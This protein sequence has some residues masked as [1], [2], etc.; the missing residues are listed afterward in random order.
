MTDVFISYSRRDRDFVQI[1]HDALVASKFQAWIDWQDIAP[2]AEWWKEIE[3]GIESAHT[4]LF[5]ISKDSI[6]SRYCRKEIDH[7][8]QHGKRLIPILRRKDYTRT[9]LHP[10]LGQHQWIAFQEEDDFDQAFTTLVQA[11]NTDLDYKKAHTRW[12]IRAVEWTQG[13]KDDS[14]LLRGKE[15]LKAEEW[16]LKADSSQEPRPTLLQK[17]Y[18]AAS[19]QKINQEQVKTIRRQRLTLGVLAG[20]LLLAIGTGIWAL[21]QRQQAVAGE[22]KALNAQL[23]AESLTLQAYL[24]AGLEKPAVVQ[25]M[26]TAMALSEHSANR[27]AIQD[28]IL[29]QALTAIEK[30]VTESK[31]KGRLI[32]HQAPIWSVAF[33]LDGRILATASGDKTV[34]LWNRD[35]EELVT[36]PHRDVVWDV[37]FS[38]E[39]YT[40]EIATAGKD[41]TAALWSKDGKRLRTFRGHSA[42]IRSLAFS[43][44]GKTLATAS[45]DQSVKLWNR[46]GQVLKT[47]NG[48]NGEVYAVAFS[49]RGDILATASADETVKIW[50]IDGQE[51]FTLRGHS[52]PVHTVAFSH[53]GET[54]ASAGADM[55][56][57]LWSANGQGL[58]TFYGHKDKIWHVAFGPT[59]E[60]LV[61]ASEDNTIKQWDRKGRVL[62]TLGGHNAR[63]WHVAFDR[64]GQ[65]LASGSSDNTVKLWD[66]A[67][68]N[69]SPVNP[70]QQTQVTALD[71]AVDAPNPASN[72]QVMVENQVAALN[73]VA[74]NPADDSQP[75]TNP[76]SWHEHLEGLIVRG[77]N[78]LKTYFVTQSPDLLMD[79]DVCHE[80]N[81]ALKTEVA[82]LLA[83]QGDQ[84][85]REGNIHRAKILFQQ[86]VDWDQRLAIDPQTRV[87]D[88]VRAQDLVLEAEGLARVGNLPAAEAKLT[89]AKS[90]DTS[91]NYIPEQKAREVRVK[92]LLQ[93]AEILAQAGDQETVRARIQQAKTLDPSLTLDPEPWARGLR[94]Q[95]LM[96]T[97]QELAQGNDLPEAIRQLTGAKALH[98]SLDLVPEAQAKT[99]RIEHLMESAE[100]L[101]RSNQLP[102]AR[103]QLTE[104]KA[105]DPSLDLI[106]EEQANQWRVEFLMET[107]EELA[108]D[109]D[110][111]TA[112]EHLAEAKKLDPTLPFDPHN[113]AEELAVAPYLRE[114]QR[115]AQDGNINGAIRSYLQAEFSGLSDYITAQD[116]N[117]I[118]RLG[119]T[120]D[121]ATQAMFACQ[122]AVELAPDDGSILDSRGIAKALTGNTSGAITDFRSFI[123]WSSDG[124]EIAQRQQW[125]EALERNQNPFTPD[126]LK[127]LR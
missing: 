95:F 48:H 76:A 81:P 47:L 40:F 14:A 59:D 92:T 2:T 35:G 115:L 121:Q 3:T 53:D 33:S 62:Q 52:R 99:W 102:T 10:K 26:Q 24:E 21:D 61:S 86:A 75:Q 15:L 93:E 94:V 65:T 43:P 6:S 11:I 55:T 70:V 84:L 12:E 17:E 16:L 45:A 50:S 122:K 117:Q 101:A 124:G 39:R 67:R 9:D 118:C 126:V 31:E 116:W 127:S 23:L 91:L 28:D 78:W 113:Q 71:A 56:V 73:P 105:L 114:G 120:F 80:I 88:L 18:I 77:C 22:V 20:S 8:I 90:L 103:E 37:V 85:A 111:S 1:L 64:E 63:V 125:I 4:F 29:A 97:A 83:E 66:L 38:P 119:S 107:A 108:R 82:P 49:P 54:L 27:Q 104:A 44:D 96:D 74:D 13:H 7:A 60:T 58:D 72:R 112:S 51:L 25:A 89:E 69:Q 79:L 5:V 123:Q 100:E 57:K 41:A 106:P 87:D 36:L 98:P 42:Q 68:E 32:G 46:N 19:R 30:A 34:K 110:L 109:G